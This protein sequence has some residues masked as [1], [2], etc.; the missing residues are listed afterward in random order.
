VELVVEG[1]VLHAIENDRKPEEYHVAISGRVRE[2]CSQLLFT[3]LRQCGVVMSR[4]QLAVRFHAGDQLGVVLD[5]ICL[6]LAGLRL[7]RC[8]S[9]L[10]LVGGFHVRGKHMANPEHHRI[11]HTLPSGGNS[12]SSSSSSFAVT[13]L[14]FSTRSSICKY[15]SHIPCRA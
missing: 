3:T 5:Q 13:A 8:K 6:E 1:K 4:G 14:G 15:R 10:N 11:D 9:R 2:S 12:T 7:L